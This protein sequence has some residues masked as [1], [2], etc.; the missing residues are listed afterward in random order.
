MVNEQSMDNAKKI[1]PVKPIRQIAGDFLPL[2]TVDRVEDLFVFR[3]F[4]GPTV[5]K[6]LGIRRSLFERALRY[7]INRQRDPRGPKPMQRAS[8]PLALRRI[9]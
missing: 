8:E 6:R 4:D 5:E 9:A 2:E 1:E 7:A 3:E